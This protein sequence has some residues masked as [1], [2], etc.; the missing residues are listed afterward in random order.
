MIPVLGPERAAK[1]QHAL[2][3]HMLRT[4][5]DFCAE[6]QCDLEVRFY[7]G[8]ETR[9]ADLFGRERKYVMQRGMDLGARLENAIQNA[10][11]VAVTRVLVIGSDC[12]DIDAN[13]LDEAMNSLSHHDVVLG[14]AIDGGY[15]LIGLRSP[16]ELSLFS[17]ID[18]GS[19]R[20]LR[21]TIAKATKAGCRIHLLPTLSDVDL[22]EDLVVCRRYPEIFGEVQED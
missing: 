16:G 17:E 2:T 19:D 6:H 8:D 12:P 3:A 14:P 11:D 22:P 13:I 7:G 1:L 18:W 5:T 20:V 4:A 10:F 15:Y 9:M 21:Q